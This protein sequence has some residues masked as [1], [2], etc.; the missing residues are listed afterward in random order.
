M[1]DRFG[2]T[3]PLARRE[4]PSAPCLRDYIGLRPQHHSASRSRAGVV[5]VFGRIGR[6]IGQAAE[7]R[8]SVLTAKGIPYFY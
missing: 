4:F 1:S 6:I 8:Q 2:A 5:V 3:I 7:P